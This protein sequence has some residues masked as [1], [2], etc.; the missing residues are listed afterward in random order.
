MRPRIK[1]GVGVA[2]VLGVAVAGWWWWTRSPWPEHDGALRQTAYLQVDNLR[3]GAPGTVTLSATAHYTPRGADDEHTVP[4]PEIDSASL[5]LVDAAGV[6]TPLTVKWKD[7]GA[8]RWGA[9]TLP[10]V[11]DG[12]YRIRATYSTVL[13]KGELDVPIP[14]YTPARIHVITDRPLYEPGNVMRF[15][16]VVLRARDLVP[17]DGRPGRWIVT[18]P[19]NEVVLEE[20]A[21]AGPFGV[22]A[23]SFP[24]DAGAPAGA[25]RVQWVSNDTAD[26]V[27]VAVEPFTLPRFRVEAAA[28]KSY[29]GVGGKP[30]IRGTVT[31]SSGAPVASAAIDVTWRTVG[32]WQ[33]PAEWTP[34][35][36]PARATTAPD[37]RFELAL[38]A[39]PADLV[40]TA[41][42]YALLTATDPAGDRIEAMAQVALSAD[43]ILTSAVTELDDGLV[44]GFNNRVYL[45]V[46]TPDGAT[47]PAGTAIHVKRAWQGSDKG[48]D[49]VVDEDGVASLQLDPGPPVNV[50][51][52]APPWRPEPAPAAVARTAVEELIGGGEATMADQIEMDRWLAPLAACAKWH[53]GADSDSRLARIGLRV[54]AAGAITVGSAA[55]SPLDRCAL[56]I[57]RGRRLPAGAE[58]MYAIELTY[59]DPDLPRLTAEVV[60]TAEAPEGLDEAIAERAAN[61]RDCLPMTVEGALPRALTWRATA[62]SR[63]VVL[64]DWVADPDG[65]GTERA[66]GCAM[67]RI[68]GGRL[69]LPTEASEDTLGVFKLAVALPERIKAQR[70]QATTM[71][72]Y[73]FLVSAE[74]PGSPATKLR[75]KPGTIPSLRMRVTPTLAAAGA[76]VTAQLIR[77]PEFRGTLPAELA[78]DCREHHAVERL[79]KDHTARLV[80]PAGVDGWCQITGG[81]V[82]GLVYVAPAVDLAVTVTPEQPRYGPGDQA[83]LI[84]QTLL[85]G[86]GGEAAVGLFGVDAS[87][88][89]LVPL[90]GADDLARLRPHAETTS[91]AFDVL[92]AQALTAGRIRGANAQAATVLR[93]G[94]IPAPAELDAVVSAAARSTFDPIAELTDRFYVVLAELYVQAR[95]WEASAPA[96]ETMRP[97]TM[98]RLWK[99]ALAACKRRGERVDDAYGRELRL[100]VLPADLLALTDPHVVITGTRLPEDIE[101]WAAWVAQER[102]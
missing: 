25:W 15:R 34:R 58:R 43:G 47:V 101:P 53:D 44:Q 56:A 32:E 29:Y 35:L 27:T 7:R 71:L 83:T 57:V 41:T 13:G 26:E 98:A 86:K 100:R 17:L 84:V 90:P 92:D 67:S 31:Y 60:S 102:P 38:P 1:L 21:P 12:D 9:L 24:L 33:P 75:V 74:L 42:I 79:A 48:I 97:A 73:E 46:T 95:A 8:G 54:S 64:G 16:A 61:A 4:V 99:Q 96:S 40:G 82:R 2:A 36:L 78:L 81:G 69:T 65:A 89:Q 10:D 49:A 68:G 39:I 6:A 23:G 28:D 77:G 18:D 80:I 93:V 11:P 20:K 55:P 59:V 51:I 3:R 88:G 22:V 87:L 52:P 72:G 45:R 5:A 30:V 85:G 94:A 76:P 37:G 66:L 62:G 50:V 19:D 91:P 14:L 70:P 63:D